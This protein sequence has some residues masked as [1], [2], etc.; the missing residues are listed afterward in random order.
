MDP[1][2]CST[3]IHGLSRIDGQIHPEKDLGSP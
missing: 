1:F 3:G 2:R